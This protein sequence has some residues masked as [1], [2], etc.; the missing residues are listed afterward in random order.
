MRLTEYGQR[1]S[2]ETGVS[3]AMSEMTS[4]TGAIQPVARLGGGNP[5][6]IDA[7]TKIYT[8]S[9]RELLN[10]PQQMATMLGEY[11]GPRGNADFVEAIKNYLNKHHNLGISEDNITIT[12]GSQTGYFVLLNMLAG[13]SHDRM[14][15]LLFPLTPEYLGYND[16]LIEP[17]ALAFRRPLITKIGAHEFQYG[18]DFNALNIDESIG[19]ICLSRPTNPSGNV[20]TDQEM[21]RL[22]TL[23]RAHDIPLIIDSAYG[24]PF[25][26]IIA[27]GFNLYWDDHTIMSMSLS[28]IGLPSTH[29]GIFIGPPDIM[30]ALG[31][32]SSTV[33]LAPPSFGQYLVRPLL[34][35]DDMERVVSD[36][37]RPY[38]LD[39]VEKA[40]QLV[41]AHFP[42]D[43]PWRLHTW[44]GSFFFW[45][46]L[47]G[48][49]MGGSELHDYLISRG[50]VTVPGEYFFP[51]K[52]H[53]WP[54][55]KQCIRLDIARPDAELE[56]GFSILAEAI[57]KAY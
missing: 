40:H 44:Q 48:V 30:A 11:D 13:Q 53:E 16:V 14:R 2:G 28:K 50:V 22:G 55:T 20:L 42:D 32:A 46:W 35:G 10:D 43:L 25:P 29:V 1:I 52:E 6:L 37:I 17:D 31:R 21:Q 57:K 4:T 12:A 34:A 33:S 41:K 45:L 3:K 47:D 18:I 27:P 26:G 56:A 15:R 5:A 8:A 54:H 23:A 7:V 38:Y 49:K 9:V 36:H 39:R 51:A 24:S 19:A